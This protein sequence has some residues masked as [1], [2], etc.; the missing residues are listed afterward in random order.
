MEYDKIGEIRGIAKAQNIEP[1]MEE[2]VAE[3]IK[4]FKDKD[5]YYKKVND[6]KLLTEIYNKKDKDLTK[7]EL[8]FLYQIDNEIDSFGYL[9]DPRIEEIIKGRDKRSDIA[10]IFNCDIS[11]IALYKKDITRNTLYYYGDLNYSTRKSAKGLIIPPNIIGDLA[12]DNI[13][14]PEGLVLPQ[15]I[16]GGLFLGNLTSAEGIVLPKYIGKTLS[17]GELKSVKGL[18][19]PNYIGGYLDLGGA[20]DIAEITLPNYIE[21]DLILDS[22]T[23]AKGIIL[24]KNIGGQVFMRKLENI[25]D[26]IIPDNLSYIIRCKYFSITPENVDQYRKQ[27]LNIR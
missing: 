10:K 21:E 2:V 18:I 13:I 7:E 23:D 3:K 8:R 1:E 15:Y 20:T 22:I 25:D 6:M 16:K 9:I 5:K 11:Q 19:F 12:L 14:S 4:D 24:P 17:L 27:N 26:L